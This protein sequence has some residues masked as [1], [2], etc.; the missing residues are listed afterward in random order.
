MERERIANEIELARQA[1]AE[2]NLGRA[3][4]CARRAA[5]WALRAYYQRREGPGWGGD[6]LKQ[7]NRLQA[8]PAAPAAVRAMAERLTTRVDVH[9]R[10]PFDDDPI[11]D[12]RGLIAFALEA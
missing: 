4:V 9:H 6:A 3:R 7:L 1:Q 12:A 5:G 10:L 8:D 11:E 2:G